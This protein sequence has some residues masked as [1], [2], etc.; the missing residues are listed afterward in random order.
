MDEIK[1]GDHVVV[2]SPFWLRIEA[3]VEAITDEHGVAV[4][5]VASADFALSVTRKEIAEVHKAGTLAV[6]GLISPFDH[7]AG[8]TAITAASRT[9]PWPASGW[10]CRGRRLSTARGSP[11]THFLP[12]P[13][14]R[15]YRLLCP[16]VSGPVRRSDR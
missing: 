6:S 12:W 16:V 9:P 7:Q 11:R 5:H 14:L 8:S 3:V 2:I 10:G 4:Y 15:I 13:Y 1:I